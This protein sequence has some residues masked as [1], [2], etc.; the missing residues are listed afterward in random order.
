MESNHGDDTMCHN[1]KTV[2][3]N[4]YN[5]YNHWVECSVTDT[6]THLGLYTML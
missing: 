3:L 4:Y 2:I 5:K 1:N 6:L